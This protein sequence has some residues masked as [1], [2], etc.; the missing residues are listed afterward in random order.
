[1]YEVWTNPPPPHPPIPLSLLYIFYR[2]FDFNPLCTSF[3]AINQK[4]PPFG[5]KKTPKR[6]TTQQLWWGFFLLRHTPNTFNNMKYIYTWRRCGAAPPNPLPEGSNRPHVE[7][8][9]HSSGFFFL[10]CIYLFFHRYI[11]LLLLFGCWIMCSWHVVAVIQRKMD[12][13]WRARTCR[14]QSGGC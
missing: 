8:P 6:V 13:W 12:Q 4:P 10:F 9:I 5:V 3:D 11:L 7:V 1:M 2:Q 14:H